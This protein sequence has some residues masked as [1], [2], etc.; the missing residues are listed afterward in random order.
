MND[1]IKILI[2]KNIKE[3][4]EILKNYRWRIVSEDNKDYIITA[5][6]DF[7]RYNLY[8]EKGIIVDVKFF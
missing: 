4:S 8:L 5:D 3:A 1:K 6:L 7:N 2:G